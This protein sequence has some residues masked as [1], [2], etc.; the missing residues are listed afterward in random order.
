MTKYVSHSF[1]RK[2]LLDIKEREVEDCLLRF[3]NFIKVTELTDLI[4][5]RTITCVENWMEDLRASEFQLGVEFSPS[6]VR[7]CQ[8][9]LPLVCLRVREI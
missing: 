4:D 2:S 7:A 1:V 6:I 9:M 3:V 5:H 8:K